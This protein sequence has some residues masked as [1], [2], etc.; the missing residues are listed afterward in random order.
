MFR[1]FVSKP[2]MEPIS[3][4]IIKSSFVGGLML[5]GFGMLVFVLRDIFAF[6]AAA[7]FFLAGFS[8][9][10]YAIRL[11]LADCKARHPNQPYRRNVKIHHDPS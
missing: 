7:I 3:S 6:L 2:S 4:A 9:I 1:F 8:A 11:W 10:G 5:I